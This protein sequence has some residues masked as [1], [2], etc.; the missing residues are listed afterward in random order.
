MEIKYFGANAIRVQTKKVGVVVDDNLSSVGQKSVTKPN[1][2]SVYTRKQEETKLPKS[3][4]YVDRPGEYEV[5]NVS[6]KGVS[7]QAHIDEPGT[8]NA[9]MYRLV[10]NDFKIGIIG[11]VYP[12]ISE[13]QLEALGMIDVLFIPVGG[14]GYTL[15]AIG[16]LKIIKKI[17]PS[18]VVPTHYKDPKIKYEVPQDSIED[19]R[20]VF[21]MEPV[22][23][24][25]ALSLKSREFA[26]GTRLVILKNV[27]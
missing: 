8:K 5:M 1:D 7:A 3:V 27:L 17:G 19:V 4:F 9:V 14:N 26:E 11:H 23:E 18:I 22:E 2:L 13:E 25:E 16:A 20:K 21:S 15:D 6:I 10:I 24:M 12:D